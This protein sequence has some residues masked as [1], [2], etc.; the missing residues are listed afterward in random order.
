[1]EPVFPLAI[2]GINQQSGVAPVILGEKF[3]CTE[4]KARRLTDPRQFGSPTSRKEREKWGT[5]KFCDGE[6]GTRPEQVKGCQ[7]QIVSGPCSKIS[8][9]LRDNKDAIFC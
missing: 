8:R 2:Q 6:V 4:M 5:I 3:V 7:A 1:M 9:E